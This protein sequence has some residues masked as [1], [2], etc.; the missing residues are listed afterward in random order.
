MEN[1]YPYGSSDFQMSYSEGIEFL[2]YCIGSDVLRSFLGVKMIYGIKGT[3][4]GV[5]GIEFHR[6]YIHKVYEAGVHGAKS[7]GDL[8]ELIDYDLVGIICFVYS[9]CN[10]LSSS[11][12]P[13]D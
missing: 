9:L 1:I 7:P 6:Q 10:L 3:Q 13:T 5:Q 8:I 12:I 2:L 11:S 4:G